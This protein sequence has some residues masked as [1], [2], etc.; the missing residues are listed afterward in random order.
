MSSK[1]FHKEDIEGK[2]VIETTGKVAGKVKD[3]TFSLD[4]T[5][6]LIV[7]KEDGTERPVSLKQVVGIS[8]HVIV[9]GDAPLS[10]P[11][12]P[13]MASAV[14]VC[15]FCGSELSPTSS[16]CPKCGRSQT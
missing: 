15:K 5:I 12:S 11:G 9:R 16:W 4:G 6:T 13:S 3:I 10:A 2:T 8:D 1:P 7:L 14:P